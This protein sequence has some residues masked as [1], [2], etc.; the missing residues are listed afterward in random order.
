MINAMTKTE[1]ALPSPV[2]HIRSLPADITEKE[3]LTLAIPFGLLENALVTKTGQAMLEFQQQESATSMLNYYTLYSPPVIRGA[4]TVI[5][6]YSKYPHLTMTTRRPG[7]AETIEGVN[8]AHVSLVSPSSSISSSRKVLRVQ[9]DQPLTT[10]L[11][12]MPF[13]QALYRFGQIL[14]IVTFKSGSSPQAFVE[15]AQT[16]ST[17]VAKH[18]LDG[19]PFVA[20]GICRTNYSH[21][22]TLEVHQESQ[23]CR[24]FVKNP[25]FSHK[26]PSD[27]HLATALMGTQ[28]LLPTPVL[29]MSDD[30]TGN[31][32][33]S[34]V[35][36]TT[37]SNSLNLPSAQ[38]MASL[39]IPTLTSFANEVIQAIILVVSGQGGSSLPD[40]P[41]QQQ[42]Q[43]Q[44]ASIQQLLP[45]VQIASAAA[46]ASSNCTAANK[47]LVQLT[48][49]GSCASTITPQL[50]DQITN[51]PTISTSL[52][53]SPVLLVTQLNAEPNLVVA[54]RT[55]LVLP[56][57]LLGV[58]G[59]VQRVKILFNKKDSALVQFSDAN[60]ASLALQH[61]N[62]IPLLG[63]NIRCHRSKHLSVTIGA[64]SSSSGGGGAGEASLT[65][66]YS[67]SRLHR[68]RNANS[69]NYQNICAPNTVLHVSGM[70]EDATEEE[71][72]ELFTKH[73][74]V[75]PVSTK[76]ME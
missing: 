37:S 49:G 64:D 70:P 65:R 20:G 57:L 24:D 51:L 66:D 62:G 58:Y 15:F 32:S 31:A 16:A 14:R 60:Q 28:P 13:Y 29:S 41:S 71:L 43:T 5:L 56:C 40:A 45:L 61:L 21:M 30:M 6:Q 50:V 73:S 34:Q 4:H 68:F 2:L 17:D 38:Q 22:E 75:A 69:R 11:G 55:H 19:W 59:D 3:V 48:G 36:S 52:M 23:Y 8:R 53:A 47:G 67:G 76:F 9:V 63:S 44:V 10:P 7:L 27:R 72:T 54:R 39:D 25:I 46:A 35:Q 12:Y 1:A 42:L 18:Q 74:G 26:D 33:T